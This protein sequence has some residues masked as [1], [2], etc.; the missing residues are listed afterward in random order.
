MKIRILFTILLIAFVSFGFK[1]GK[2]STNPEIDNSVIARVARSGN[3][4]ILL[5]TENRQIT[6]SGAAVIGKSTISDAQLAQIDDGLNAAFDGARFDNLKNKLFHGFFEV[7]TPP[8]S[9]I[10]SP[11]T[12]TPSFLVRGDAYDGSEFDQ[13]NPRGKNV[14]DGIGVVFAA[15]MILSV[16]TE[17]SSVNLGQM[18]VCPEASVISA[19]AQHGADH[20]LLANNPYESDEFNY[21]WCSIYHTDGVNH[22][23]LPRNGR[24]MTAGRKQSERPVWNAGENFTVTD[25]IRSLAK[26]LNLEN[27]EVKTGYIIKP[28][29]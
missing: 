7:F 13:Y 23:L 20:I 16:G 19:A 10:P 18:Y 3:G 25:E 17:G 14:A 6:P 22:P 28:V 21:F 4:Q 29:K 2:K 27:V 1:C 15:E 12:R 26:E 5:S 8:Y 9:C 11:E 24:C